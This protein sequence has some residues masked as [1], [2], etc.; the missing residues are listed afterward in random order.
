MLSGAVVVVEKVP[1]RL[2]WLS[3]RVSSPVVSGRAAVSVELL[4]EMVMVEVVTVVS[5]VLEE[6]VEVVVVS[7]ELSTEIVMVDVVMVSSEVIVVENLPTRLPW[8]LVRDSA[9]VVS[10]K[11]EEEMQSLAHTETVETA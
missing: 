11:A 2:P 1:M 3:V 5:E 6:I 8:L 7:D 4:G 9:G 10:G